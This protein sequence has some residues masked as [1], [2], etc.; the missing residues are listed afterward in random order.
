MTRPCRRRSA[1]VCTRTRPSTAGGQPAGDAPTWDAA[2]IAFNLLKV[3]NGDG[4]CRWGPILLGSARAR[5]ILTPV[6]VGAP[7]ENM[8]A[9]AVVDAREQREVAALES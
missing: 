8:T 3:A 7:A 1:T 9:L 6:G 5:Y 2:N 4:V